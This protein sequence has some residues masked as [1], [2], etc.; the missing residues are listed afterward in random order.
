MMRRRALLAALAASA[1][2]DGC[3]RPGSRGAPSA[4]PP[5]SSFRGSWR[6]LTFPPSRVYDE[7]EMAAV[8]VATQA[9]VL[10]ALRGRGESG[11]GL[12]AGARGWRDD[13][14]LDR[15]QA[16]CK[17]PPLTAEDFHGFVEPKR[18]EQLNASLAAQP[19]QGLN[20]ACPHAPALADRS[21][22]GAAPFGRF[23]TELL[24][25]RVRRE[26]AAISTRDATGIDGVSMGGR[27]ALL[28]G[29]SNPTVFGA[30]GALQ[31]AI[32]TDEAEPLADMAAK[33]D[34][35]PELRLVSSE[36]DPFLG[37]VRALSKA[38]T[39]RD[40]AHGLVVTPG[41]HD[42]VWNKGP[43]CFEML[44]WHERVLRGMAAP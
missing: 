27:L 10:I 7:E 23:L 8:L 20:V 40:V 34:P 22:A 25:P 29:L 18:L 12:A 26:V 1:A 13:Y 41:P 42:Y 2:C 32:S 36:G 35:R 30:V 9:P 44:L 15:A 11:R 28:I 6:E 43:G 38:L 31:P 39:E 4:A 5:A 37:A 16:R 3:E 19:Y 24:L 33:A 17:A 14:E 21:A